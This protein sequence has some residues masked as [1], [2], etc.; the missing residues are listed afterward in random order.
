MSNDLKNK[1]IVCDCSSSHI[2]QTKIR[3]KSHNVLMC[4]SC[5]FIFL[6]DYSGID[7]SRNYGGLTLS[8]KWNKEE[9]MIKRSKSLEKFNEVVID[10]IKKSNYKNILEIG[11]GNGASVYSLKNSIDK[12]SIDCIEI[13]DEDRSFIQEI[14]A[15]SV[16]SKI[17]DTETIY[18]VIYGHHVFEHFIDPI[19]VLNEIYQVSTPDCKLYFSFTNFDDFYSST[20][21]KEQK[22]KYLTFNFHLAHPYY[23]TIE[24]FSK[25]IGKTSWKI[26]KISTVQDYSVLNYFNW[27]ING[28]RSKDIESGTKVNK[29]IDWINENFVNS[30]ERMQKGNNISVILEKNE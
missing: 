9:S 20:L 15:S 10:I 5:N 2:I 17:L 23:Y 6:Q 11:A 27:Y 28:I 13:N 1:C 12:L 16:Y 30:I 24:T 19:Q 8:T 3:E 18:D 25:L 29:D 26:N 14:L 21:N 4:D 7:Y 22:E